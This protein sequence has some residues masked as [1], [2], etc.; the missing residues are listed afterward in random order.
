MWYRAFAAG[1]AGIAFA[2]TSLPRIAAA[3]PKLPT[4]DLEPILTRATGGDELAQPGNPFISGNLQIQGSLTEPLGNNVSVSYDHLN[5]G[6]LATTIGRNIAPNGST[7]VNGSIHDIVDQF[8]VDAFSNGFSAETGYFYR[9]RAC[10]PATTDPTNLAPA[11]WHETY[12]T[13]GYTTRPFLALHRTTFSYG[14]TGHLVPH[15]VT[16]AYLATLPSGYTDFNRVETG[17]SQSLGFQTPID[18]RGT[19][20]FFGSYG[21]GT[22]DYFDNS[23]IPFAYTYLDFRV[24]KVVNKY[25]SFSAQTNN[26]A[27]RNQGYPFAS[28]QGI[29]RAYM[30]LS[31]DVK[32]GP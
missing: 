30:T 4:L 19:L 27:Q 13:L 14:I 25:L 6:G 10:C 9:Q 5:A 18:A 7:I 23:P 11:V 24:R 3:D 20:S 21:W 31:A 16:A 26:L 17:I 28:P 8:R 29:H 12:L 2:L 22:M 32:I 1:V 15:H